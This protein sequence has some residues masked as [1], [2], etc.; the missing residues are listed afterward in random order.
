[1]PPG[2]LDSTGPGR[3]CLPEPTVLCRPCSWYPRAPEFLHQPPLRS[4]VTAAVRSGQEECLWHM[5]PVHTHE[6]LRSE[7]RGQGRKEQGGRLQWDLEASIC[8]LALEPTT[9][10]PELPA[11]PS[12]DWDLPGR[13]EGLEAWAAIADTCQQVTA[14]AQVIEGLGLCGAATLKQ[15]Q[16]HLKH[17]YYLMEHD[18]LELTNLSPHPWSRFCSENEGKTQRQRSFL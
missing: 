12:C 2:G 13:Q 9:L 15:Y 4:I 3:M 17:W 7:S 1:M 16:L 8:T 18:S 11:P 10:V 5:R 14:Q 6:D